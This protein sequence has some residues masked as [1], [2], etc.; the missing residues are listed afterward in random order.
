MKKLLNLSFV[1]GPVAVVLLLSFSACKKESSNKI[2]LNGKWKA[3]FTAV[4]QTAEF[5]FKSNNTYEY[6]LS[7]IDSATRKIGIISKQT[8]KYQLKDNRQSLTFNEV[9]YY[10]NKNGKPGLASG[11]VIT[12]G[13]STIDYSI[14]FDDK[15]NKF[16]LIYHCGPNELCT[17]LFDRYYYYKQ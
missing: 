7:G 6:T 13:K 8:G 15:E 12:A 5:E 9:V 3:S 16:S 11:L 14:S 10:S 4:N 1:F 17:A 2:E